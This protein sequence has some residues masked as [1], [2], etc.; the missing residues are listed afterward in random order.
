[1]LGLICGA[2]IWLASFIRCRHDLGLENSRPAATV[3]GLE[4][5]IKRPH[6]DG[7]DRFFWILLR[8]VWPKWSNPLLIVKPD[9]VVRWHGEAFAF[10]GAFAPAANRLEDRSPGTALHTM[11]SEN[12]TWGAPRIYGELLI[13][14]P[15]PH[16]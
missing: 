7:S 3:G 13:Q 1:M 16:R 8:R 6:L 12:P 15:Q 10:T 11:A 14:A 4:R 2:F 5:R 9:T